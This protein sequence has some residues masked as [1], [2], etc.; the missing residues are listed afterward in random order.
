M[1]STRTCM[2]TDCNR[3]VRRYSLCSAHSLQQR[4]GVHV[5]DMQVLP[6]HRWRESLPPF[7]EMVD[8][9]GP[10]LCWVYTGHV[11]KTGYG[12]YGRKVPVGTSRLAHR[13]SYGLLVEVVP[14]DMVLDHLCKNRACVNPAHLDMVPLA[15]NTRRGPWR[16]RTHCTNG[17]E[18][19]AENVY[20]DRKHPNKRAC[21]TCRRER[22][23]QSYNRKRDAS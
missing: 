9:W 23:I 18:Y 16:S 5:E 14:D 7:W 20:R 21:L 1:Q 13:I 19:T 12:H 3:V 10:S 2:V 4:E 8:I 17:H 6:P 11:A 22:A 15:E